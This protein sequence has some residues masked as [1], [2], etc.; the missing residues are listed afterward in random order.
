MNA[1]L[2]VHADA[3]TLERAVALAIADHLDLALTAS[4]PTVRA[5]LVL[6][7]GRTP[8]GVY[9]HLANLDLAWSRVAL[10]FGDERAVPPD[11]PASNFAMVQA[12][13]LG[14]LAA[15]GQVPVVYRIP[16]ELGAEHAA[17][18]YAATLTP[19]IGPPFEVVL[20]GMGDDGH[21][22]SIF[23]D[24]PPASDASPV[25][26]TTSPIAPHARVSLTLETL[27]H[28]RHLLVLVTGQAKAARL[29]EVLTDPRCTL[30]AARLMRLAGPRLAL[31]VDRLAAAA[32]PAR[33]TEK[34][35]HSLEKDS[36]DE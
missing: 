31:H 2:V 19:L 11:D 27:T 10:V 12:A 24:S 34:M 22:A 4:A 28:A 8:R 21:V 32:L 35:A 25:I 23:P 17:A 18:S 3:S 5:T 9:A 30:P 26:A 1:D 13:L 33:L 14:P 7:G 20:L 29:A 36:R 6:A 16:G 15:R